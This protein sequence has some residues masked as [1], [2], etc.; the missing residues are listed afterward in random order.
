[1]PVRGDIDGESLVPGLRLDVIERRALAPDRGIADQNIE[2]LIA[3]VERRGEPVEPGVI[4]HVERH[5]C[6]RTAGRTRRVVDFLET[7][8]SARHGDDM[9]TL[10][11]QCEGR[12]AADTARGAGDER[13][14]IS[15][16]L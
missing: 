15:E 1:M 7:A 16:R 11:R 14:T 10:A 13:D 12:R 5:Q 6:R 9:C 3:F 4:A 2:M 8:D